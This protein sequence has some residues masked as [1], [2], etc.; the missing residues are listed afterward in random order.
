MKCCIIIVVMSANNVQHTN[1]Y[2][3]TV[4]PW[5]IEVGPTCQL[6][7]VFCTTWFPTIHSAMMRKGGST[8]EPLKVLTSQ[9][10]PQLMLV[11]YYYY[12]TAWCLIKKAILRFW[13]KQTERRTESEGKEW[14]LMFPGGVSNWEW[15]R[16]DGACR[17]GQ[18]SGDPARFASD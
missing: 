14:V 18:H 5:V 12:Y 1:A 13:L 2:E 8:I 11:T 10:L 16:G 15:E 17:S 6:F 3:H 7:H 9:K 4:F